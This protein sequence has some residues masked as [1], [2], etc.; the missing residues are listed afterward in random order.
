[1]LGYIISDKENINIEV[2]KWFKNSGYK[3]F[4][5]YIDVYL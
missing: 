4:K 1:M 2:L 3:L 5:C